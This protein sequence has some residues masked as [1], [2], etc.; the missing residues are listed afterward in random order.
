MTKYA[1]C[2]TIAAYVWHIRPLTKIG[3]KLSGG[4]DTP[5]LCEANVLWDINV[6]I[7]TLSPAWGEVC[8]TCRSLYLQ[9]GMED[10]P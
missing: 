1:Y 8:R 9:R 4:A 2:E 3:L 5:A 6:K 7:D 10:R